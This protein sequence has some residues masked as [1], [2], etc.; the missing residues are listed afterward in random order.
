MTDKISKIEFE[1]G[2]KWEA[3]FD[4]KARMYVISKKLSGQPQKEWK[5]AFDEIWGRTI[6]PLR[7]FSVGNSLRI[8]LLAPDDATSA[9]LVAEAALKETNDTVARI[10]AD[11]VRELERMKKAHEEAEKAKN[12]K[13]EEIQRRLDG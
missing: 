3:G 7:P 10:N 12:K 13:I 4:D 11:R 5:D 9:K 8:G 1:N 6:I 2:S